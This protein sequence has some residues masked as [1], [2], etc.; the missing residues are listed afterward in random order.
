[1]TEYPG[2][3]DP[4]GRPHEEIG[5]EVLDSDDLLPLEESDLEMDLRCSGSFAE[6]QQRL[7]NALNALTELALRKPV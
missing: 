2:F 4:A 5:S 3:D 1:M 7:A 6:S